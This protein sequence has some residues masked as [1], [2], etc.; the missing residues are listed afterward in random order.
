MRAQLHKH[1][2]I[3]VYSSLPFGASVGTRYRYLAT[4]WQ[5]SV[6]SHQR[7]ARSSAFSFSVFRA[8]SYC[9]LV[10]SFCLSSQNGASHQTNSDQTASNSCAP[11]QTPNPS[12][13]HFSE[14]YIYGFGS[15]GGFKATPKQPPPKKLQQLAGR[16]RLVTPKEELVAVGRQLFLHLFDHLPE[17]PGCFVG[18]ENSG[19]GGKQTNGEKRKTQKK[20][21][22]NVEKSKKKKENGGLTRGNSGFCMFL[23]CIQHIFL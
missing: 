15:W 11:S 19:F 23:S 18:R 9:S 12:K 4:L 14:I 21:E 13:S 7:K 3:D 16:L 2:D 10:K 5:S 22:K 20:K 6:H 1:K 17:L 8:F